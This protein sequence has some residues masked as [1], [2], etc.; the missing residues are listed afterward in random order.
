MAHI[1][2]ITNILND[3]GYV[4]RTEKDPQERF[5]G[6][7]YAA[8]TGGPMVISRAI[9]KYG[10]ENFKFEV[11]EECSIEDQYIRESQLIEKYDTFRNGYNSSL[12]GEGAGAGIKRERGAVHPDAKAVDQYDLKGKYLC[13]Y[14]SMG[15]GAYA[16][17]A[18]EKISVTSIN[19]CIKGITFQAFGYRWALK[20]E[21]LKEVNNRVNRR[22]KVYGI[23]LKSGR[24]KMWKSA[25]DAAEEIEGNRKAN[26]SLTHALVRNDKPDTTKAQVKG[27]YLFRDKQIALG[28]W[29][30]AEHH[31]P[32]SEEG[33]K[34]GRMTKGIPKP[35][36]WKPIKGV[37]VETG[38]VVK[39]KHSREAVEKLRSDDCKIHQS[40]IFHMIKVL[41]SG[42]THYTCPNWNGLYKPY[43]HAGY[44]WYYDT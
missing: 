10:V 44:R 22:G 26:N 9:R 31:I 16:S 19:S 34:G 40:G 4:G 1:Y 15:E 7:L 28:E 12:G 24:K 18:R 3:K 32:T 43:H 36:F 20:G 25:A 33:A 11:L 17:G 14:D 41:K 6:H 13:T 37:H 38:E 39:F 29:K 8:R 21:P 5:K 27:W 23:H 30:P 42:K 35:T 2:K